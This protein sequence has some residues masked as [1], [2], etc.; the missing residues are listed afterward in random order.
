VA[1]NDEDNRQLFEAKTK[2]TAD[3]ILALQ[4]LKTAGVKTSALICPVI[5]HITDVV[6]LI[7]RLAEFTDKIWI[8]GL[9]IID[10]SNRNWRN[11]EDRLASHFPRLK[12]SIEDAIFS[13][14]H[15]YWDV[16]RQ[17]L[18]N[19]RKERNLNLSIHV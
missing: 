17:D 1:F 6:L 9:S 8:Y 19:V 10:R 15:P 5:P 12:E 2:R 4:Q 14:E 18:V 11:V 7:E 13:K 3:R 16:L